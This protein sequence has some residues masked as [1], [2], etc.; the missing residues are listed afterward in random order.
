MSPTWADINNTLYLKILGHLYSTLLS[1]E[2][3]ISIFPAPEAVYYQTSRLIESPHHKWMDGQMSKCLF[4][5][6]CIMN[7]SC[8]C[9]QGMDLV[10]THRLFWLVSSFSISLDMA[11]TKMLVDLTSKFADHFLLSSFQQTWA[12]HVYSS[13]RKKTVS[14]I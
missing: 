6:L 10:T 14:Q 4:Q 5:G 1:C 12:P 8:G 11:E 13:M 7:T 2:L 3:V 9:F